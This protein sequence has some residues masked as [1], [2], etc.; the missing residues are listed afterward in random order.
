MSR[1]H[2]RSPGEHLLEALLRADQT[3]GGC[4]C[5]C[6]AGM[7]SVIIITHKAISFIDRSVV[8]CS[9][10]HAARAL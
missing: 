1:D 2:G 8:V 9:A 10:M 4:G 5:D 6:E 7:T 3:A